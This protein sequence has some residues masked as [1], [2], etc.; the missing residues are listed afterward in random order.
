M[1]LTKEQQV[2]LY[3]NMVRV[4]K[5]D[6]LMVQSL[7]GGKVVSFFHSQQG[8]EA[9]G[10]GVCTFLRQDDYLFYTHR[11]HGLCEVISKGLP[12]K[13][14]IAEHYGKATGSCKGIAGFHTSDLK[15]GIFGL[16]GTVGGEFTLGAGAG[17]A[18]KQRGK[19]QVVAFFF[20]DGATGRG[21]FHTA[22]L[23][24]AYWKLPVIWLCS[25]NT[26]AQWVPTK[27]TCPKE[28][29]ADFAFGY[30]IPPTVVDGQNVV[31][32]YEAVQAA[33]DRA[34][35]GEGPSFIEFKTCRFRAHL[36]G[37]PDIS[38]WGLRSEEEVE[39]W[40]ERDP[41][42]LFKK[43]LLEQGVLT[44]ADIERIDREA[45]EEVEE[46][47]RFATES[48]VPDPAILEKALYAD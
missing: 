40:K 7:Y 18:A 35:A 15:R 30:G 41:I 11:G 25:N 36:E 44:E 45:M 21:T 43:R 17:V 16:G 39:V 38:Q 22:L 14:F 13:A 19:G 46:A 26:M 5:L 42:E 29:L 24:S 10:V 4:R 32:V 27:V 9:I 1:K 34:R 12:A 28:N 47:D 6:E 3:T 20:G 23:M 48:P 33:V 37:F 2:K 8:Q 31:A